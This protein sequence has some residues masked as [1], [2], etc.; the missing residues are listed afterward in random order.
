MSKTAEGNAGNFA[1]NNLSFL[2]YISIQ[3]ELPQISKNKEILMIPV[4]LYTY[5]EKIIFFQPY[6][7]KGINMDRDGVE[8][9]PEVK[10]PIY[11]YRKLASKQTSS[12]FR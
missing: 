4:F 11:T 12:E 8:T 7:S 2:C 6:F 5:F 10:V 9:G 3:Q 1:L